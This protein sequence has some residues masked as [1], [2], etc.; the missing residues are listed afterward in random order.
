MPLNNIIV[1]EIFDVFGM[2]FMCPFPS[3][4]CNEYILIAKQSTK[5]VAMYSSISRLK[6]KKELTKE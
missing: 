2:D 3:S 1:F 4:F 5:I 6:E